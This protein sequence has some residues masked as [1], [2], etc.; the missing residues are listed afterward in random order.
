MRHYPMHARSRPAGF[1]LVEILAVVVILGIASAIIVPQIGTRNDLMC[2]SAARLVMADL[3]YAQ[4]RA[5][6]TQSTVY[7]DFSTTAKTY[8]VKTAMPSTYATNPITKDNYIVYF[9]GA[10]SPTKGLESIVLNSASFDSGQ[11][12]AFD[13]LGTPMVYSSGPPATTTAMSSG[14]IVLK[15]GTY[16]LT[17]TIEANTGEI[18]VQ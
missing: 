2:A 3:V 4:N 10:T 15:C 14:N 9:N 5:I 18:T 8:S 1:T 7:V 13:E 16:T 12:L 11:T 6:A 17:I